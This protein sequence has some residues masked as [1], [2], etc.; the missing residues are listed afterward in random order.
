[1]LSFG[2]AVVWMLSLGLERVPGQYDT[3][4]GVHRW[5]ST[6]YFLGGMCGVA[7][8]FLAMFGGAR[9]F[10]S[11]VPASRINLPS[12]SA[13]AYWTAAER[14]E[15]FNDVFASGLEAAGA[16]MIMMFATI[17][18]L[19]GLTATGTI[20]PGWVLAAVVVFFLAAV[21]GSFVYIFARTRV[22][23]AH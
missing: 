14:R 11:R 23:K 9:W 3:S 21:L 16:A 20:V 8:L 6:A 15:A 2:G 7:A 12:R 18:V 4:G 1:M 5:D 17:V 22:P 19:S 13:H 10:I